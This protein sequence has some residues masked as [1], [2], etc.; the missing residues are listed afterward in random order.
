MSSVEG[1]VISSALAWD[2]KM[3]D[4]LQLESSKRYNQSSRC[5]KRLYDKQKSRSSK[6]ENAPYWI[7]TRKA[8]CQTMTFSTL[9]LTVEP[10]WTNSSFA[11]LVTATSTTTIL[12]APLFYFSVW[13]FSDVFFN[14]NF[15]L[16]FSMSY[17]HWDLYWKRSY[18]TIIIK[19]CGA[20]SVKVLWGSLIYK[21]ENLFMSNSTATTKK[22]SVSGPRFKSTS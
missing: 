20:P 15:V 8:E 19:I 4:G 22:R 18:A 14:E 7:F 1:V 3:T 9:K 21:S 13:T 2:R 12:S 6:S 11:F 17:K 16:F 5:K 10:F